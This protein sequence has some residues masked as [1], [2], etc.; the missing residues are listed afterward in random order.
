MFRMYRSSLSQGSRIHTMPL[1]LLVREKTYASE[2]QD[3]YWIAC[4]PERINSFYIMGRER[5]KR[6]KRNR[7]HDVVGPSVQD[8]PF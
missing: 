1:A 3:N 4:H 2:T 6:S 8:F 7:I 5:P